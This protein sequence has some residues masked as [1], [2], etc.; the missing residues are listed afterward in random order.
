MSFGSSRIID[1]CIQPLPH[2]GW[3]MWY[4]DENQG[5]HT[6]YADSIDVCHWEYRGIAI[7]DCDQEGPNV[8]ALGGYYWLIADVWEGQGVYR[9]DDLTRFVRQEGNLLQGGGSRPTD[10]T[11]GSHADV[12]RVGDEAYIV[13]FTHFDPAHPTHTAVQMARLYV[14]NGRLCCD[15]DGSGEVNWP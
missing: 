4:K 3:R 9:S 12:F 7:T 13:Y 6:C 14:E 2:G 8:F 11:H 1:P 15:R 5:S 10:N